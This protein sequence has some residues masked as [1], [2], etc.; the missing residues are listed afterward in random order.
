MDTVPTYRNGDREID[1][2]GRDVGQMLG[3]GKV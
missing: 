1:E 3:T 2:T